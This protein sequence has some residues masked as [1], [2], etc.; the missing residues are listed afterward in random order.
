MSTDS[1]LTKKYKLPPQSENIIELIG[2]HILGLVDANDLRNI[3]DPAICK[4]YVTLIASRLQSEMDMVEL[5]IIDKSLSPDTL[6]KVLYKV[7]DSSQSICNSF[8]FYIMRILQLVYIALCHMSTNPDIN[9]ESSLKDVVFSSSES[10][11]SRDEFIIKMKQF[12]ET[13][14]DESGRRM[15]LPVENRS[16]SKNIDKLIQ[17]LAETIEI[18]IRIPTLNDP[19]LTIHEDENFTYWI[20]FLHSRI[21]FTT[22][23]GKMYNLYRIVSQGKLRIKEPLSDSYSIIFAQIDV[24][25]EE[26]KK[27]PYYWFGKTNFFV[28]SGDDDDNDDTNRDKRGFKRDSDRSDFL[29][30]LGHI[31]IGGAEQYGKSVLPDEILLK[32]ANKLLLKRGNGEDDSKIIIK[33]SESEASKTTTGIIFSNP[34]YALQHAMLIDK[35]DLP[36]EH[37]Y[38]LDS[39]KLT[40]IIVKSK[41]W[42]NHFIEIVYGDIFNSFKTKDATKTFAIVKN[43]IVWN[44]KQ[45]AVSSKTI[46]Y[47]HSKKKIEDALGPLNIIVSNDTSKKI[48]NIFNKSLWK[49]APIYNELSSAYIKEYE[50]LTTF[51]TEISN[52]AAQMLFKGAFGLPPLIIYQSTELG[53]MFKINPVLFNIGTQAIDTAYQQLRVNIVNYY[54]GFSQVEKKIITLINEINSRVTLTE[55]QKRIVSSAAQ[56]G[57]P[58]AFGTSPGGFGIPGMTGM[59]GIRLRT[60]RKRNRSRKTRKFLY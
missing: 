44:I 10:I 19:R 26:K 43:K 52:M 48:T 3:A 38:E 53:R 41:E 29:K 12:F 7:S 31:K 21:G 60:R 2:S 37:A 14:L 17:I 33:K 4:K 50:R 15:P 8:A 28:K 46:E 9:F 35:V 45:I 23:T 18:P 20:D 16:D 27:G 32:P 24:V 13:K 56:P 5:R 47:E 22:N 57:R 55:E 59:P 25:K 49:D 42:I 36:L 58:Q 54:I 30:K 51:Q 6:E 39:K 40:D 34:V 11:S 1:L